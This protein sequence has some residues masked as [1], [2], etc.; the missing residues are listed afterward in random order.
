MCTSTSQQLQF[1][2]SFLAKNKIKHLQLL[3]FD[4]VIATTRH[5]NGC[6]VDF[7]KVL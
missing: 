1:S 7:F 2:L 3:S 4:T 6:E 5:N